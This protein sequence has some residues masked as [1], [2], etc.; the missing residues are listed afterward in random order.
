MKTVLVPTFN[1]FENYKFVKFVKVKIHNKPTSKDQLKIAAHLPG[2]PM[3]GVGREPLK[4]LIQKGEMDVRSFYDARQNTKK[5]KGHK[6][7][8]I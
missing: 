3:G 8:L 4:E 5:L 6:V 7:I 2:L 1:E